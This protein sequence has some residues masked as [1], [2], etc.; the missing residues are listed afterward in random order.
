MSL[1]QERET[2]LH[3][4]HKLNQGT[5]QQEAKIPNSENKNVENSP[6]LPENSHDYEL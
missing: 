2:T 4:T 6:K 1:R 3:Y 5:L